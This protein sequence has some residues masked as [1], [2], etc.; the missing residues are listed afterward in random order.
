MTLNDYKLLFRR[1]LGEFKG[2]L[3]LLA[4]G[5]IINTWVARSGQP[6][7]ADYWTTG[8]SP[9]PPSD[10]IIGEYQVNLNGYVPGDT[11]AM[12]DLYFHIEPDPILQKDGP[13]RRSEIGLHCDQNYDYAP[14]SAGC[15]A[16]SPNDWDDCEQILKNLKS[17]GLSKVPLEVDYYTDN[18]KNDKT[19]DVTIGHVE[20]DSVKLF[21]HP[22]VSAPTIIINGQTKKAA[23]VDIE[24]KFEK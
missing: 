14:G 13:G 21:Y 22:G 18:N 10:R 23:S 8:E 1:K 6:N 15:I 19:D 9:I 3:C 5:K 4:N 17:K 16:V 24:I 12:G 7:P 11:T 2:E 20:Y